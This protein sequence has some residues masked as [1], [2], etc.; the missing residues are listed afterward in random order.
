MI[1]IL[2]AGETGTVPNYVQALRLA[3]A[4]PIDTLTPDDLE[5]F[6]GLLLPGGPD[7]DPARYGQ[8]NTASVL[9]DAFLE[10]RQFALLDAFVQMKKPI[11]GICRGHQ[12]LHVYFGG[13]LIQ[14]LPCADHHRAIDHVDQVHPTEALANSFLGQLY[15]TAFSTNSSHHQGVDRPG[16][17]LT[18]VQWSEQHT[19]V[20]ASAHR[21]LPIWSVQWHPERMCG[22]FA[23]T[24]TVD[25]KLIFD[26]FLN[27]CK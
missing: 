19:V 14:D 17:D 12:L 10:E 11:L 25:G 24:D 4:E 2:I 22:S 23:R 9:A 26:F 20:E 7:I 13:T 6:D 21:T 18:I 27:Q 5:S 3:G 15:G 8:E 1:K 16:T